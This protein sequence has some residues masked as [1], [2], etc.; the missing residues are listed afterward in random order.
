MYGLKYNESISTN[1]HE[2]Y[3]FID[4]NYCT[5]MSARCG[6]PIELIIYRD[7]KEFSIYHMYSADE[8][9]ADDISECIDNNLDFLDAD[10]YDLQEITIGNCCFI[11]YM[12]RKYGVYNEN[13]W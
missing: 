1:R 4:E 2:H 6:L 12:K 10:G 9:I 7:R 3:T 8:I 5:I 11:N 13:D